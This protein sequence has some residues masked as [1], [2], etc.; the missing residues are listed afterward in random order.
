MGIGKDGYDVPTYNDQEEKQIKLQEKVDKWW[1]ELEESYK[2]EL[3]EDYYPDDV[4]LMSTDDMWNGLDWND[5]W[6]IYKGDKD[7]VY[8]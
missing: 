8:P 4:S 1:Y 2:C 7:E 6:G 3:M 5:K